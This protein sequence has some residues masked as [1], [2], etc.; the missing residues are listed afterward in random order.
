MSAYSSTLCRHLQQTAE[1]QVL[2][3]PVRLTRYEPGTELKLDL[4]GIWPPWHG[5]ALFRVESYAGGG[6]TGQVYKATLL[7]TEK[8]DRT[9]PLIEINR[10]YALRVFVPWSKPARW[11]RNVVHALAFQAPYALQG[12]ADAVRAVGLWHRIIRRAAGVTFHDES[13]VADAFAMF[14]DETLGSLGLVLEWVEGR[15]WRIELDERL[16][17]V[18]DVAEAEASPAAEGTARRSACR[19]EYEAKKAFMDRVVGLLEDL[20]A[21]ELA[22]QYRWWHLTGQVNV[23]KRAS[24][25]GDPSAGLTAVDF[26]SGL[27]LLPFAPTSPSDVGQIGRGLMKLRLIQFNRGRTNRLEAFANEHHQVFRD[28]HPA[29]DALEFAE[30]S[31]HRSQIDLFHRG[32]M[33]I[34]TVG[35]RDWLREAWIDHHRARCRLDRETAERLHEAPVRAWCYIWLGSIPLVG[36]AL[37]RWFGNATVRRHVRKMFGSFGYL[38]RT[39]RARQCEVLIDWHRQGRATEERTDWLL[40]HQLEFWVE[41][42]GFGLAPASVHRFF[43]DSLYVRGVVDRWFVGPWQ[44]CTNPAM[45]REMVVEAAEEWVDEGLLP[46]EEADRVRERAEGP[47][48]QKY[49]NGFAVHLATLP[50]A[51]VVAVLLAVGARIVSA[52]SWPEAWSWAAGVM[53]LFALTPVSPGSLVRGGYVAW[54]AVRERN[55]RDYRLALALAFWK[56]VGWLAFPVQMAASYPVLSRFLAGRAAMGLVRKVPLIGKPGALPE[57]LAYRLFYNLPRN[58]GRWWRRW[59]KREAWAR[60]IGG[61]FGLGRLPGAKTC[62]SVLAIAAA[63]GLAWAECPWWVVFLGAA[64]L[65]AVGIVAAGVWPPPAS[66]KARPRFVLDA[67]TGQWLAG[68]ALW[69]PWPWEAAAWP[70]PA[71]PVVAGAAVALV[72]YRVLAAIRPRPVRVAGSLD[73]G[74]GTVADDLVAGVLAFAATAACQGVLFAVL[75]FWAG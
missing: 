31:Y 30:S 42:V 56:W 73:G 1:Q 8:T 36:G 25:N 54:R 63:A 3:R 70:W 24:S 40:D 6:I 11:V 69:L 48:V 71:P 2:L 23:L 17:A 34:L 28:L 43:T 13:A 74:W 44:F 66:G 58:L 33:G 52:A 57:Y 67:V 68:L 37:Q 18:G 27:P 12:N 19:T 10:P 29:I 35:N 62:A 7:A 21:D 61:L 53:G 14:H 47:Q 20:G 59:P 39:L 50:V 16:F 65:A 46:Q 5:R 38:R 51:L 75:H 22:R 41:A 60:R 64:G 45:R 32:P 15:P 72:G 4:G 55:W 49:I 9:D 26:V